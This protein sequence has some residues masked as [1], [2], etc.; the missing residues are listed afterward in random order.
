M[1]Y[2]EDQSRTL[3]RNAQPLEC[4]YMPGCTLAARFGDKCVYSMRVDVDELA[5]GCPDK[6]ERVPVF[7]PASIRTRIP[8]NAA[9]LSAQPDIAA[10]ACHARAVAQTP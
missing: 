7:A 5:G 3:A 8:D 2:T 9:G 4:L 1:L 6:F 10:A